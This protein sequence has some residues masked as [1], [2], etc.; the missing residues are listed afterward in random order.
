MRLTSYVKLIGKKV[1]SKL[2]QNLIALGGL[3][4]ALIVSLVGYSKVK[5]HQNLVTQYDN[6]VAKAESAISRTDDAN[7]VKEW[8]TIR[9]DLKSA[10][11]SLEK[12]V[13]THPRYNEAQ[14]AIPEYEAL[15]V[16]VVDSV[17]QA[18]VAAEAEQDL[19]E[20]KVISFRTAL[21][22]LDPTGRFVAQVESREEAPE[23]IYIVVG[24]GWHAE[25]KGSRLETANTLWNSWAKVCE[26]SARIKF[27]SETGRDL[28]GTGVFGTAIDLKD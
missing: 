14:A 9:D 13:S 25:N 21:A 2:K 17:E 22:T 5:H 8:E 18:K 4:A 11:F 28:G 23:T 26:C 24:P 27:L 19:V 12:L 1:M 15:Q 3:S 10:T 20:A 7:T 16:E 6:A